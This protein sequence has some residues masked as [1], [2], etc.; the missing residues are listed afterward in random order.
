MVEWAFG[1][2]I[3]WAASGGYTSTSK[4]CVLELTIQC[5]FYGW[6]MIFGGFMLS[7][8]REDGRDR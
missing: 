5:D 3:F 2:L 7:Y 4:T 1:A 6:T 8:W